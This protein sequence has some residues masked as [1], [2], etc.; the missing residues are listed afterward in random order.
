MPII[1][2]WLGFRYRRRIGNLPDEK[3]VCLLDIGLAIAS[4]RWTREIMTKALDV[5]DTIC[6]I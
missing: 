3:S 2:W 6:F 4:F 5:I 1:V